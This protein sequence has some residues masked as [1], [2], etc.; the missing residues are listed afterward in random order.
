MKVDGV[1]VKVINLENFTEEEAKNYVDYVRERT[2]DPLKSIEIKLCDDGKV[3]VDYTTQGEK[4]ERIRRITGYLTGDLNSW[5]NAK[6]A[7]EHERVKHN[8]MV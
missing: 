8:Q 6:R 5:N 2:T 3:D 4:F 7:E 1:E